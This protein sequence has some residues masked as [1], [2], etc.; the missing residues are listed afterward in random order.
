MFNALSRFQTNVAVIKKVKI[1]KLLYESL[2]ELYNNNLITITS[3]SFS[4]YYIILMKITNEFKIRLKKVYN[5][6]E[7]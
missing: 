2:I 3:Q 1:L 6:N 4:I 7:H 5:Q